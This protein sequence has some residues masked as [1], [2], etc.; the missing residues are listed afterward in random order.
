MNFTDFQFNPIVEAAITQAGYS[1]PTPIQAAAIPPT[2][3]GYDLLATA[4]TGTGKTAAYAL[5]L[6]HQLVE[7][8]EQPREL[9]I[10]ALILSPTR[11]LAGQ[12]H[13]EISQYAAQMQLICELVY[14]G[15]DASDQILSVKTGVDILIATP[16]RLLDLIQ[17]K[18][19]KL[20]E[21]NY[22]IVD[23][24]DRMLDMGFAPDIQAISKLIPA[25]RQALFFSATMPREAEKLAAAILQKPMQVHI[26]EAAQHTGSIT[27]QLFYVEKRNKTALLA[28]CLAQS[29]AKRIL[30]FTRT[31]RATDRLAQQVTELGIDAAALHGEKKQSQR[32]ERIADFRSGEVSLLIATDLAARGLHIEEIDLI[33][34]YDLPAEPET[35]VHRIGRTGRIGMQGQAIHF[36]DPTEKVYLETIETQLNLS[37]PYEKEQPYHSEQIRH[38]SGKKETKKD[39]VNPKKKSTKPPSWKLSS[40]QTQSLHN[41]STPSKKTSRKNPKKK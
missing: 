28:W 13:H 20:D 1:T 23:E 3:K 5:P 27:H 40:L 15:R 39:R 41:S 10:R 29:N 30:V 22:L 17:Q 37:L 32:E 6:L 36:C 9:R 24:A 21:T 8:W 11:E 38:F 33:I 31:R 4:P 12:I 26:E 7:A 25:Q 34:N 2:L 14:G 18:A 35:F 19:V 16:G